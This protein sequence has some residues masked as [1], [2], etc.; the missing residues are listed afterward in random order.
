MMTGTITKSEL[1]RTGR[2]A[3]NEL[4]MHQISFP[5]DVS[6]IAWSESIHFLVVFLRDVLLFG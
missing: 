5:P 3:T 6:A 2:R 1:A 4:A